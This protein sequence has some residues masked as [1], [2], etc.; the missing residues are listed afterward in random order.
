MHASGRSA[1]LRVRLLELIERGGGLVDAPE[2]ANL[3]PVLELSVEHQVEHDG[4]ESV[5]VTQLRCQLVVP[6][7][8]VELVEVLEQLTRA[9]EDVGLVAV[10]LAVVVDELVGPNTH[11]AEARDV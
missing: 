7:T 8:R 4:A 5:I 10:L 1:G 9:D 6:A 2:F 11:L 3:A